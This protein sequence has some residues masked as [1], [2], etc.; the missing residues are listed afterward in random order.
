MVP[1]CTDTPPTRWRFSTTS[2][3]LPSLAACT[4]ALRYAGPEPITTR[5]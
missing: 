1:V 2:T 3:D 4:A 5:S